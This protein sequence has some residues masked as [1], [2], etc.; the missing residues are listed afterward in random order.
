M[1]GYLVGD[2]DFDPQYWNWGA[3][4]ADPRMLHTMI[5]VS[6]LDASLRFYIGGFGMTLLNRFDVPS[7]RVSAAYL[8]YGG[9]EQ[10]GLIE[11]TSKWEE[12]EIIPGSF[13]FAIGTPDIGAMLERLTAA[14][15]R[16]DMAPTALVPGGPQV[17]FI[18]DPDGYSVELIQ[19]SRY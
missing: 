6:D 9:Y 7:R 8:G 19:T 14:G 15:A 13:H 3:A 18:I 5:R 1:M 4:D 11:L 2:T 10:G 17:A 16:V 12:T